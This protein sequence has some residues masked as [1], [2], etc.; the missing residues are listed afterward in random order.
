ME[1]K[2]SR[3]ILDFKR[4]WQLHLML[5]FGVVYILVF[6]YYPMTGIQLAFKDYTAKAGIWGSKWVGMKHFTKFF[7]SVYFERT[8]RNTLLISFY[9]IAVGFPLPIIFALQ[10]NIMR[11][12]KLKKSIQTI[13]Y[14][15]HFISTVVLVGMMN[16]LLSPVFGLYGSLYRLF[17]DGIYPPDIL[18]KSSAFI[19]LYVWSGVWQNLGWDSILYLAALSSVSSELHEAAMIDGASRWKRVIH[20]DFPSILPTVI[21]MLILRAGNVLSVGFE[22]TYLMQNTLNLSSSE[23]ISTYVYKQGLGKGI[24]GFSFGSAVG[25]FNSVINFVMLILVNSITKRLS[26]DKTSLF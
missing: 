16:Q 17:T 11:T 19:H 5:L 15:P 1:K 26:E 21:I 22:K 6:A 8:I 4:C 9:S 3:F 24:R 13:T 14:M 12:E 7:T 18:G 20:I 23:V 10:L 25:L 2:K